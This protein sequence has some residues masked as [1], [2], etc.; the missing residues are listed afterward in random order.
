[1][2]WTADDIPEQTGHVA[3]VTGANG[4]LGLETAR[5]LARKG[6]HVVMAA[7][8]LDKAEAARADIES[9]VL[10]ASLEVVALDL[11]SM[12]S[13]EEAA[14]AILDRH[15][16]IHV[17]VNNAGVMATPETR[18][19]DGF[20]LQFATNH[21][22]HFVLTARLLP[23]LIASG[24]ARVVTVTSTARF[25]SLPVSS[26]DP[27][28]EK[29]Y[30]SWRAYGQSKLANLHFAVE[31][32]RRLEAAGAPVE[33]LVAHPGLT[34]SD[35]QKRTVE[36]NEGGFGPR[37]WAW[38]SRTTGM[39]VP[40]G[41]L[42]QLRATTDPSARGGQLYAPRFV[43]TGAAVRRPLTGW[44]LARKPARRLWE[45]S[46]RETGVPFDVAALARAA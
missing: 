16:Q 26:D 20:E 21:L 22:G 42:P 28:L 9:D 15:P 10:G 40:R 38:L 29:G 35:L 44:S 33:S 41:A 32:N 45:V 34:Y 13:V 24:G 25:L 46:E 1:V 3:V 11:S 8:N 23:A 7:R 37:F 43:N 5:E 39:S 6:A 4:G 31:L 30:G 17:L 27:H 18:T 14:A 19:E 36:A 12:A 2:S